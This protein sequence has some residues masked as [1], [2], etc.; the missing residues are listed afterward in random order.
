MLVIVDYAFHLPV[1]AGLAATA[2]IVLG[3]ARDI[4]SADGSDTPSTLATAR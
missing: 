3:I 4:W 1:Y 2:W